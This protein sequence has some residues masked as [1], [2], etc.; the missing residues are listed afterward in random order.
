M[1]KKQCQLNHSRN[2]STTYRTDNYYY[3]IERSKATA[4]QIKFYR[5]LW[6]RFKDNGI[7]L[8]EELDKRKISRSLVQDPSGRAEFSQAIGYMIDILTELGLYEGKDEK[9]KNFTPSYN[10]QVDNGSVQRVWQKIEYK[11]EKS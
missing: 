7:D 3:D 10:V 9:R 6:Y 8:N 1:S 5:S 11:E 2:M 4:K